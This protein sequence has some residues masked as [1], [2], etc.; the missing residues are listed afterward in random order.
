MSERAPCPRCRHGN[1]AEN[2]FCGWCGAPLT[3]SELVPGSKRGFA[4]KG[5][6]SPARLK[7]VGRALAIGLAALATEAG[8]AWLH[9]RTGGG[10]RSPVAASREADPVALGHLADHSLEEVLIWTR[11]G[12]SESRLFVRRVVHSW[13]AMEPPVKRE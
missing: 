3:S 11:A 2:R 12:G 10:E 1:P 4:V 8:L 9:R 13:V 7:P 6:A 5:G